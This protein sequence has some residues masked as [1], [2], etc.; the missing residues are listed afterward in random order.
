MGAHLVACRELFR[1][2]DLHEYQYIWLI[3]GV[4]RAPEKRIYVVFVV[5]WT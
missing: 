3:T 5:L 4:G 1:L 2:Q